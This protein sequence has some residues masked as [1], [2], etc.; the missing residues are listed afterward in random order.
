MGA[1]MTETHCE[2]RASVSSMRTKHGVKYVLKAKG[3]GSRTAVSNCCEARLR[4]YHVCMGEEHVR[5]RA[6][7]RG[8]YIYMNDGRQVGRGMGT[9]GCEGEGM[10]AGKTKKNINKKRGQG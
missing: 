6:R 2:R 5:P 9:G 4:E 10:W 1:K 7:K 3:S 8:K